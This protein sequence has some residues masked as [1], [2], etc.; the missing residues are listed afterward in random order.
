MWALAG[1]DES[2]GTS[3]DGGVTAD[4]LSSEGDAEACAGQWEQH[5]M[6]YML[7]KIHPQVSACPL[8]TRGG[9]RLVRIVRERRGR[10]G[11]TA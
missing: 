5:E 4:V 2:A 3:T 9:T 7:Q 8:S 11:G 1:T 6:H 10:G